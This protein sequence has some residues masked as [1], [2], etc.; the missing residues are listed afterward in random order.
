MPGHHGVP[1][2]ELLS[3]DKHLTSLR[4]QQATALRAVHEPIALLEHNHIR[5]DGYLD[6]LHGA[7][8]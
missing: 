8:L 1:W 3:C 5:A 2:P 6:V 4:T 7:N